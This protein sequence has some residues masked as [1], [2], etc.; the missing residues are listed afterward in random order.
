MKTSTVK[1]KGAI[2]ERL[3]VRT[4]GDIPKSKVFECIDIYNIN[5]GLGL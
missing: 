2:M 5:R 4:K 3:P 1:I